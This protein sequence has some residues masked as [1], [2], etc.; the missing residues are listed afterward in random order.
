MQSIAYGR[1]CKPQPLTPLCYS[2]KLTFQKVTVNKE[3]LHLQ[4]VAVA[5]PAAISQSWYASDGK[6]TNNLEIAFCFASGLD[7]AETNKTG[8]KFI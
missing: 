1:F 8:P 3:K 5:P 6:V 2:A 4:I 7:N